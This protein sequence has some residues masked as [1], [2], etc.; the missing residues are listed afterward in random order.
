MKYESTTTDFHCFF[1]CFPAYYKKRAFVATNE[2]RSHE[3][4]HCYIPRL[5]LNKTSTVIG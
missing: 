5:S 3:A 4:E 2:I 1:V